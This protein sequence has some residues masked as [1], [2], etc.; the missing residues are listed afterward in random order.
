MMEKLI[1]DCLSKKNFA[2]FGHKIFIRNETSH[3]TFMK[4]DLIS[5][6]ELKENGIIFELPINVCQKGHNLTLFFIHTEFEAVGTLPSSGRYKNAEFEV[7]AKV[8]NISK[9]DLKESFVFVDAHFVQY[10]I[11]GWEK[12]L[13][14]YLKKQEEI[15]G[16]IMNQH[17]IRD[18]E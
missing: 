6:K 2:R 13:A 1:S 5:I 14:K 4:A 11:E 12:L 7:M 10:D 8:E 3:T 9:N 16:M 15:N 18:E 17:R